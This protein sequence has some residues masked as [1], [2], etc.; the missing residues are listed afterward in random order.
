MQKPAFSVK[1]LWK[2]YVL[3]LWSEFMAWC[4]GEGS[5][6]GSALLWT[7]KR[8]VHPI[9]RRRIFC[10]S[11]WRGSAPPAGL[12]QHSLHWTHMNWSQAEHP[13]QNSI[14]S[15]SH[16]NRRRSFMSQSHDHCVSPQDKHKDQ[17][18]STHIRSQIAFLSRQR[19]QSSGKNIIIHVRKKLGKIIN[20]L[21]KITMLIVKKKKTETQ[22]T[23]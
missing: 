7:C 18:R 15:R 5:V 3:W 2:R 9:E 22:Q 10:C 20:P 21:I 17:Q 6:L 1:L 19:H 16:D 8:V 23:E 13:G 14:Y 11:V 4:D 12:K